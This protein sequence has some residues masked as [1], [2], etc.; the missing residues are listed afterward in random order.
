MIP[1]LLAFTLFESA[2][3]MV[4]VL[5]SRLKLK[6]DVFQRIQDSLF[7]FLARESG[8]IFRSM[9]STDFTHQ[10]LILKG[11]VELLF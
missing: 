9:R 10:S 2:L 11:Q 5:R 1:I 8:L 3:V 6:I 7:R 4:L